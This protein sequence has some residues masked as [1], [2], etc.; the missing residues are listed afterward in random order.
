MKI[1]IMTITFSE[2]AKRNSVD[3]NAK[4]CE[5]K[6]LYIRSTSHAKDRCKERGICKGR[7]TIEDIMK[8][9]LY[10][11]DSGC[12]KYLDIKNNYVYYIREDN[13]I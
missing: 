3:P 8:F 7:M 10:T 11:K 4:S 9:P 1:H 13:E 6:S 12:T 2:I 5:S